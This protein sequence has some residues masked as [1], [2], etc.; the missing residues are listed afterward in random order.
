MIQKDRREF[1]RQTA[2]AAGGL[3]LS[4]GISAPPSRAGSG[5]P[6]NILFLLTDDH[7]WDALGSAGN[8]ILQ[9]P[10]LDRL[11]AEGV[12]FNRNFVTTA[13][14]CT[15]RASIFSGMYASR[16]GIHDFR[17]PFDSETWSQCY[18]SLLREAGY[19]MGFVGKWGVGGPMPES[20]FDYWT[21]FDGQ[22][23]YM[24]EV[25]GEVRHLTAKQGDQSMEFLNGCT[26]DRPFCLSVSFKAPHCQDGA[27][28]QFPPEPDLESLYSDAVIPPPKTAT[29][30]HFNR[31]PAFL[32]ESEARRRWGLRFA[33]EEM[34]QDTVK[35]YYRLI[36]GVD[37][38]VG[39]MLDLLS[40]KGWLDNTVIVFTGDNGFY[41]GEHGL[42]GKWFMHE[43][44]IRTP[45]LIFDPTLPESMRGRRVDPMSLNIDLSP[46]LLDYAGIAVPDRVQGESLR[47]IVRGESPSDWRTEWYYEH[48]FEHD[49]IPRTQ[50]VRT[51]RWKYCRFID[52]NPVYEEL[53][54]LESDPLEETNLAAAPAASE[55]LEEMRGK[56]EEWRERVV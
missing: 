12:S 30:E 48:L 34:R 46:T 21:G 16:N 43:E 10:H 7:R 42:A 33:S 37:R 26:A 8:P 19:R 38:Q 32:R 14:C 24:E 45:L 56:W 25:D 52:A 31:L 40:E 23:N 53:Y 55:H 44:S 11:A 5:K 13:I 4:S 39:R 27:E 22:G 54:D 49:A 15:S 20:D 50:G 51:E 41:L 36:T 35:D 17:T 1:L 47:S 6:P 18:P 9:T 29:E 28:R 2:L 3:A